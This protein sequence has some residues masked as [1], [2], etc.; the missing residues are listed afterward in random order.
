MTTGA[1]RIPS[2]GPGVDLALTGVSAAVAVALVRSFRTWDELWPLL[3]VVVLAH[4]CSW[5]ARVLRI[6]ALVAA[7]LLLA[8]GTVVVTLVYYRSQSWYGLPSPDVFSH[9]LADARTAFGPFQKLVAPVPAL[10]GFTVTFAVGLWL[11]ATFAD[12]AAARS[13]APLQAVAPLTATFVFS[14]VLL[15]GRYAVPATAVFVGAMVLYRLTVRSARLHRAAGTR[16]GRS[17]VW[18]VGLPMLAVVLLGATLASRIAPT[19]PKGIVD[20]RSLG[21]GPKARVVASPLVSLDALL[22]D[23]SDQLLFTVTSPTPHYWRLTALDNFDGVKW[24]ASAK[25]ADLDSGERIPS[26]WRGVGV[27]TERITV[28]VANLDSDWLPSVYAPRVVEAPVG[29]RYDAASGSVFVADEDATP[30]IQ[31]TMTSEIADLDLGTL[32]QANSPVDPALQRYRRLPGDFPTEARTLAQQ[33][34]AGKGTY[35]SALALEQYFRSAAFTYDRT[36]DYRGAADP[37]LAFLAERRGF[38]QQFAT[39]F[40][41]LG[42][43][44]GLPTRVAVGFTYGDP[45]DVV[46]DDTGEPTREWAVLGRYAH[47]WPEV[48]I[49]RI[50]WVAFEP[51]KG[52]GNPDAESYTGVPASQAAADGGSV[53]FGATTTTTTTTTTPPGGAA[54]TTRPDQ[55]PQ[56]PTP[57]A[58][59]T[60]TPPPSNTPTIVL[61]SIMAAALLAAGLVRLRVLAVRRRRAARRRPDVAPADRVAQSWRQVCRDLA[62]V[63]VRTEPAETPV[64]FARRA[65]RVIEIERLVVLGRHESDRRFRAAAPDEA[66]AT[67]A[68]QISDEVRDV[69]WSRLDRRQRLAA[70][71]DLGDRSR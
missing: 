62:R 41:A 12:L 1:R 58:A 48:Y 21:R 66:E 23:E 56:R 30:S 37:L 64:E 28:D 40:A 51:T 42:R 25:Y 26:S 60:T 47:A 69:V 53:E 9:A 13:D 38:C 7:P 11:M 16:P 70:D 20:L 31:Y 44:V 18:A 15:Q 19:D 55:Q 71:L 35:D 3:G 6:G 22:G 68:E 17:V 33:I 61:A 67:S 50:G 8:V 10:P 54:P 46:D 63:D 65:A 57:A 2:L 32:Q 24:S 27:S 43:S 52:R 4:G 5:L 29:L 59:A 45:T 36:A 34:T 39:A 14:S 49:D